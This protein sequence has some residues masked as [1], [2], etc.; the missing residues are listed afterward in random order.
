MFCNL[1]GSA[2]ICEL[3]WLLNRHVTILYPFFIVSGSR[4]YTRVIVHASTTSHTRPF[5]LSDHGLVPLRSD[6][7]TVVCTLCTVS[8][9]RHISVYTF[10]EWLYIQCIVLLRNFSTVAEY[11]NCFIHILSNFLHV[12]SYINHVR[13][14]V[15]RLQSRQKYVYVLPNNY[16]INTTVSTI[17]NTGIM[18]Y[19][20]SYFTKDFNFRKGYEVNS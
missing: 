2:G 3:E 9:F 16:F 10:S 14:S 8:H 20:Y 18:L 12:R 7:S 4:D 1:I 17:I 19:Y 11:M 15:W 13:A 5:Q 6:G